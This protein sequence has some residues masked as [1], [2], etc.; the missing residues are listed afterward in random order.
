ME[1]HLSLGKGAG[2][3][4]AEHVH[5]AQI[6]DG[7]QALDDD[8]LL[9]HALGPVGQV[10][11]DD[12]RQELRSEPHR[13]RHGEEEGVEHRPVQVHV[14]AED[15]DHENQSDFAEEVAEAT[16]PVLELGLGSPQPQAV[17]DLTEL[18]VLGSMNDHGRCAPAYHVGAHE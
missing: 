3:V 10:D 17:R 11:A 8:L 18:G 5:A 6:L 13:E 15:D 7:R 1:P 4:R 12:G 16:Y 14:D 2:L 9:G